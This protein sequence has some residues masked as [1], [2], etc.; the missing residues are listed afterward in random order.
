MT[1]HNDAADSFDFIVIGAGTAGC[2]LAARLSE[3]PAHR[4]CLIEAGGSEQHPYI[5]IPAAVGA[6]IMSERFGWNLWTTP[7]AALNG[8]KVPLP[9]GRV[10]GG[11]GSI[12]GMAYYRGSARDYDDWAAA[13]NN[14]WSYADLLPYFLRS[15]D[16]P[17]YAASPY[18]KTG[19]P[20]AVRFV[21]RTN[22]LCERFNA[23]MADLGYRYCEDFNVA[24]PD[25]YGYR[26]ATIHNGLRVSTASAYLRP[27]MRRPNLTVLTQTHTRRILLDN[28][29]ATGVEIE[30]AGATRR[31][32]ARREVLLCAGAFHSPHVLL[33]SGIGDAQDL[34]AAGVDVVHH[35]PGVG[36]G[37]TD[38]PASYIAMDTR[39]TTSYGLSLPT[40]LRNLWAGVQYLAA[41]SGPLAS[42][43]FETNA[44][45]KSHAEADRPDMQVVFQPARRNTRPFPLP[46]GH[47]YAISIVCLYPASR[48]TVK[49]QG[50]DPFAAPIIDPALGSAPEDLATIVRG[51]KLARKILGTRHFADMNAHERLPGT[52]VA[53]DAALEDYVRAT[54][55]T[56]HHPGCTCRMGDDP[57]AVVD[58]ELKVRGIAGL[59]VADASIYPRLVGANTNASVVAIAEKAADM[60]LGIAAP[61][62]MPALR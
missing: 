3:N 29:V 45:I 4:V 44:Y 54:L 18:H 34:A 11:S 26:Q 60:V 58:A 46:L 42:N 10:I 48:G 9:R 33:N 56:V 52:Q 55:A 40:T 53:D 57:Q 25:G 13:G 36:R 23:A 35:L 6:A 14:G 24:E 5:A 39:D 37:L 7:Q 49:L 21:P 38:H 2:V 27:A 1:A 22:P 30:H 62:A 50:P 51:L 20:M 47:G 12:N 8:R 19:G 32:G 15:E 41:R 61:A 43:L 16:N 31:L 28:G 59:R 17:E